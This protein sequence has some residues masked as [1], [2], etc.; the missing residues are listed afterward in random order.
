MFLNTI[1]FDTVNVAV[2]HK[3][4]GPISTQPHHLY[5]TTEISCAKKGIHFAFK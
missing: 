4:I 5:K 2:P 3:S 1:E